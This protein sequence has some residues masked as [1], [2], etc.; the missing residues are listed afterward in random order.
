MAGYGP[1][2]VPVGGNLPRANAAVP[3]IMQPIYTGNTSNEHNAA[4]ARAS[5]RAG[6]SRT[7]KRSNKGKRSLKKRSLKRSRRSLKKRSSKKRSS[8]K[9][10]RRGGAAIPIPTRTHNPTVT[11]PQ[12]GP[13]H[14]GANLASA[15]LNGSAMDQAAKAIY[16]NPN[17]T[18][19]TRYLQ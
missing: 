4:I 2:V 19:T 3:M 6:G 16:D 15:Q 8:K 7:L 14:A 1:K 18:A 5:G 12:F 13:Q 10:S 11:V 9:R 17:A